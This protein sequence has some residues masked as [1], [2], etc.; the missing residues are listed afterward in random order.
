MTSIKKLAVSTF[1]CLAAPALTASAL[2]ASYPEQPIRL[3]A[4][5]P[6]GSLSDSLARTIGNALSDAVGQTVIVE[7]K[8]GSEG[9]IAAMYVQKAAPNGYTLLFATNSPMAAVPAMM[10]S[11]PYDAVADFTPISSVGNF[12][13]FLY[14]NAGVPVSTFEELIS[15]AKANP[16]KLSYGTANST[17]TVGTAQLISQTGIDMLQVPYKGEPQAMVDLA[18]GRIDVMWATPTTGLGLVKEGKVKAI[19]TSLTKRSSMLPDVPTIYEAGL[20]GFSI[21]SWGAVFGPANMPEDIVAR[22]NKELTTIMNDT[23]VIA[24]VER[25]GVTLNPSTPEELATYQKSQIDVWK[26]TVLEAKIPQ[27]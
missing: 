15:Y 4:P 11:P 25:Q 27:N 8:P 9:M 20:P 3:I 13:F 14:V 5:A 2:A 12:T 22:L 26:K 10:K 21:V 16:G 18:A 17:G 7:N 24:A 1:I 6:A 23:N 19:A